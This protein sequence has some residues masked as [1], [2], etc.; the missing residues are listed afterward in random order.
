MNSFLTM[1]VERRKIVCTQAAAMLNIAEVAV[2]KDFWVC[3][4]LRKLF[5]LPRWENQLTFKGGTSL[6]KCWKIIERFSED[7]DIVINR[8]ALGFG[9][10]NAPELAPSRK[11]TN[12]YLKALHEACRQ[13]IEESINPLL[14]AVLSTEI[15]ASL[16]WDLIADPA[17]MDGQTLL[18]SY[19]TVFPSGATYLRR[20]I[21]IEMG[22]RSDTDPAAIRIISPYISDVFP[23]LFHES[24]IKVRAV[25]PT[26]TFWEKAMLLHEENFR[27]PSKRRRKEYMARHYYDIYRLIKAGVASEAIAD[28]ELFLRLAK[29]RSVS[30]RQTWMDYSTLAKGKLNL[31]PSNEQMPE[32]RADYNNMQKEIFFG[33]A[34][35]FDEIIARVQDFQDSFNSQV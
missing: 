15:P 22:A 1:T 3:W 29:H 32:W 23:D 20:A 16:V 33:E 13:C 24:C 26:H 8:E 17:D 34:P 14:L 2:E 30:F 35:E 4:T 28:K 27:P 11:Q 9:G 10:A 21:K 7:L 19:P 6:S 25:L 18:F 5:G 12:K 31:V